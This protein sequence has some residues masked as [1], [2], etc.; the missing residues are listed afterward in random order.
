M[1]RGYDPGQNFRRHSARTVVDNGT[2]LNTTG[3]Q[4]GRR[5]TTNL[6]VRRRFVWWWQVLDSN[7]RRLSRRFY[8]T[9]V[10][11]LSDRR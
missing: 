11:P 10:L 9:S 3:H 8:R 1:D 7:Q 5:R 6:Q 2:A 4:R